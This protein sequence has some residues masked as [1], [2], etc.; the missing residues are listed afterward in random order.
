MNVDYCG[1]TGLLVRT[2]IFILACQSHAIAQ[3]SDV[4]KTRID[5]IFARYD[6][7]DMPGC[8][9][10]L[11]QDGEAILSKGYGMADLEHQLPITPSTVFYAGSISKQF[12]AATA[13]LLDEARVLDLKAPVHRYLADF[14]TYGSDITVQHLIYHTSGIVD[15]FELLEI[16]GLNYLNQI[17]RDTV[18]AIICR[19]PALAFQPGDK[20]AY[21]N[22]G[23]LML[24]MIMEQVTGKKLSQLV[25]EYIFE[26]LGMRHS[27]ML[28]DNRRLIPNRAW[29]YQQHMDGQFENM[30]MRFELTGSGGLYTTTG[31]LALWDAN[32]YQSRI[33]SPDFINRLLTTGQLNS[34][35]DT[36]YAFAIAKE[37][38]RGRHVRGHGG[39]LGGYRAQYLQ[40][41]DERFS[42][43]ILSNLANMKPAERA[44]D[45]ARI[46]FGN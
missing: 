7:P 3:L 36:R 10:L 38:L 12:V 28:D 46:Y 21:S 22:S 5:S 27:L 13:L 33:G 26:P 11:L 39:S 20:Y 15:Y 37:S 29:G 41:P 30:I 43:I 25:H 19:Q 9:V 2:L 32:L 34:G 16:A 31:D 17:S 40:F 42:I 45:I 8:A 24:G 35:R 4:Q 44:H 23:Y 18:Y 1:Q 6:R 14:P